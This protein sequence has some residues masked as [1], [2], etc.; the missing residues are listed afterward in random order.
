MFRNDPPDVSGAGKAVDCIDDHREED[1]AAVDLRK[2]LISRLIKNRQRY[3]SK[4]DQRAMCEFS[5]CPKIRRILRDKSYNDILAVLHAVVA[6]PLHPIALGTQ[7]QTSLSFSTKKWTVEMACLSQEALL[8][9][10][11][12]KHT[13]NREANG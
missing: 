5:F 2:E 12:E 4:I 13:S 1:D 3:F 7:L 10:R 6:I 9:C 11:V 8:V